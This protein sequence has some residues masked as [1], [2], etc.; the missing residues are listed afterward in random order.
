M[1]MVPPMSTRASVRTSPVTLTVP[2]RFTARAGEQGG[3]G[4]GGVIGEQQSAGSV[5]R[6]F[7]GRV[8]EIDGEAAGGGRVVD[9]EGVGAAAPVHLAEAVHGGHVDDHR[10]LD[11]DGVADGVGTVQIDGTA[12]HVDGGG[13]VEIHRAVGLSAVRPR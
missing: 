4:G 2:L 13:L 8:V 12:D 5:Q 7:G 9:I 1:L 11:V 10:G 3:G 6:P